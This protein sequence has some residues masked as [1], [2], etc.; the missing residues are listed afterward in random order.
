MKT[1]YYFMKQTK[2]LH[3]K[4]QQQQKEKQKTTTKKKTMKRTLQRKMT[5]L[6]NNRWLMMNQARLYLLQN[7]EIWVLFF[8]S[9]EVLTSKRCFCWLFFLKVELIYGKNHNS[10]SCFVLFFVLVEYEHKHYNF[11]SFLFTFIF[12]I[13]FF[14][15]QDWC[16]LIFL[17]ELWRP[18][19]LLNFKRQPLL[20]FFRLVILLEDLLLATRS[21]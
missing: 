11:Q 10:S 18:G 3:Y 17:V 6:L 13:H 15:S 19:K 14:S 4:K 2:R 8:D 1:F 20:L 7:L 12:T 9:F 5:N 21:I 16:S